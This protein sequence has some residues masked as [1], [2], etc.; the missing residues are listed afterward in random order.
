M[1]DDVRKLM[2]SRLFRH[3]EATRQP[4]ADNRVVVRFLVQDFANVVADVVYQGAKHLSQDELEKTTGIRKG[5]PLNPSANKKACE[6]IVRKLNEDG[7]PMAGCDLISGD[8]PEDTKVIFN[9]T[10]GPKAYLHSTSFI[11]NQWGESGRL[12]SLVNSKRMLGIF[13][14]KYNPQAVEADINK[15]EEYYKGFGFLSVRVSRELRLTEDGTQYDLIFHVQEGPRYTVQLAPQIVGNKS[16]PVEQLEQLIALKPG[17]FYSQP[18]VDG[19]KTKL[20]DFFG[21]TGIDARVEPIQVFNKENPGFVNINYEIAEQPPARV[22]QV[23]IVGNTRTKQ[24]VILRQLGFYP[25]QVLTYPEL[26]QAERNLQRIGIFNTSPDGQTKPTVTIIDQNSAREYKDILVNVEEAN[27]GSLVFGVGV[28]SNAGLTGNITLNERNFDILR[29][30]TSW[31]DLFSGN[32]FRGAGQEF[33]I[34][35]VPGT[36]LQRYTVSWREPFLFDT[37]FSLSSSA[38]YWERSY[39]EYTEEREGIKVGLARKITPE[40]T[41][42]AGVRVENV[43]VSGVVDFA[44]PDYLNVV[45]DNFQFGPR[46]AATYDT[47]DSY[48]RAT[49][50]T[51][52]EASYEEMFGDYI[53]PLL[54]LTANNYWTLWQRPDGSGK[55]VLSLRSQ[56]GFAGYNTPVY[57]R[58]FAGGINSIRGFQYRGV[59]PDIEGFKVGGDFM[60]LNSLEYQIPVLANDQV[61]MVGFIDSGTVE[62]K[63]DI[64]DYR[65]SAG[66]GFR[67]VVP[68]LGPM[69]IALDFGFPIVKGPA[70]NQQVFSFFM[71]FNH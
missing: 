12:A 43:N 69:P 52:V 42:S 16:V 35:L 36:Q 2:E 55:Q 3:V 7:R 26:R 32:A 5:M 53:F 37:P 28:N 9:I 15:I 30:P 68:M 17:E 66:F 13:A 70:D 56:V 65:V 6:A 31:D 40:I 44:P 34:E 46:I 39:N 33:R 61:F 10:E 25:G 11:G 54:N 47:R 4:Q 67:F 60:V 63:V 8:K 23:L 57:E 20:Q 59:G 49:S 38:Y 21:Y 19:D 14:T 62:S 22:G 51:M 18:K 27:T 50:G 1:Y 41:L 58:F 71:G 29:F 24:N 48:L 45:G 64:K